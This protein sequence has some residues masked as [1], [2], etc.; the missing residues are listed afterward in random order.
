MTK[1]NSLERL[2]QLLFKERNE[3]IAIYFYA[4][5]SGLL[6]LTVPLGVQSIIGF[7]LGAAMV[8]SIYVLIFVIV[9]A[10]LI[11]GL[12]QINQM[13][14]IERLQQQIFTRY[15]F[16]F[17]EN[18]AQIDLKKA[19]QYYLPEKVNRFFDTQV[20]QK[21]LSKILLDIPAASIQITLGLLLLSLYHPIFI[22]FGFLLIFI[23][24]FILKITA[25]KGYSTS[26]EESSYKY[27]V[28]AWFEEMARTIKSFKFSQGSHLN[29]KN[30]DQNV[31]KYL[32]A[33]TAH[34]KVLLFQFRSLVVF[35]VAI[36]SSMLIVGTYLLL[37]QQ[38]NIG[39]FI[40]AE[41][42]ILS[43]ISAVE[44][45][46]GS[47]DNVYD[48]ITSLEKLATITESELEPNG[49]IP[50]TNTSKGVEIEFHNVGFGFTSNKPIF[51]N[52]NFRIPAS[53]KVAITGAESVGKSTMLCLMS[54]NYN[55]FEGS[56]FLNQVP[57]NNYDLGELRQNTGVYLNEQDLFSG[58]VLDNIG[59]GHP[60][61]TAEKI[62]LL[63]ESIGIRN[64]LTGLPNGFQTILDPSGKKLPETVAKKILLLRALI[65]EPSLLLLEEPWQ[66]LDKTLKTNI[67]KYI[68]NK[69]P[70]S[71]VFVV[72]NDEEFTSKCDYEIN[73]SNNETKL[74]KNN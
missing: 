74:I 72:T 58:T 73:I 56:I 70:Y 66:G 17:S 27:A 22:I 43:V 26:L 19:D 52:L 62:S 8:T 3:I 20:L 16:A 71:T 18:I 1:V 57:I 30:T 42:V 64:Y 5:L 44:K 28:A 29:L 13:K 31:V 40:A 63:A 48:V 15:A 6:Q 9:L 41:I 47:L 24:W 67:C 14:I 7:V 35:K 32:K 12:F 10:V 23:L 34:F 69:I 46:I 68:F 54:G 61:N 65:N 4:I 51:K 53:S 21:G 37:N 33:K 50:F 55:D 2:W 11:V 60:N 59:M 49:N 39:E 36:T 45:L 38:L 25:S